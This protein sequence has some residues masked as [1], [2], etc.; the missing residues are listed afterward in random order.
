MELRLRQNLTQ[1]EIHT[2]LFPIIFTVALLV[3]ALFFIYKSVL[4]DNESKRY[5]NVYNW[6][7]VI[8]APVLKQFEKE[9]G[10][11]LRYDLFDNNEVVEAKLFSGNSGYDVIFP[12]ASP[13]VVRH[14]KTGIY[15]KINKTLLPN[16]KHVDPQ[17]NEK[18]RLADPHLEYA[19][20]YFW[21][22][23]GFLYV[24]EEVQKRFPNAP[25]DSYRMLFDPEV[26]SKFA[27]CGVTLLDESVDI[28]PAVLAYLHKD[29]LSDSPSDLELAQQNLI[30]IRKYIKRFSS[31]RFI[32]E[33]VAGD[34]CV[35]Q[36]WSG[37][38]Q[39]AQ[40]K[41]TDV[42]RD[43]HIKYV[44]PKEG[45]IIWIDCIVI[46]VDAPHVR[47]AHEFINFLL[48]PDI[49]A[50]ITNEMSVAIANRD[51]LTYVKE[52]IRNDQTIYPRGEILESLTLD[53]PQSLEY[54]RLR[55]DYM[56]LFKTR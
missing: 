3:T 18:M 17:I 32:N 24:E 56:R 48:R 28:Y 30:K 31:L 53:R 22:T 16:L 11:T 15:Q 50:K 37:D 1:L 4:S 34:S 7:G 38:A 8:P 14:I 20:P 35:A 39:T 54:E 49:S 36:A 29:P 9:T 45:G 42:G 55:S 21:G 12:S 51:S 25:V 19:I 26:V 13:Y 27:D 33:I 40:E 23:F 6:Y 5:V 52:S 2:K 47:E 43:V 46:P 41:A 10:I 44:V